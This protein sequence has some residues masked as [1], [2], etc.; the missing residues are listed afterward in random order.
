M[1][2]KPDGYLNARAA[3]PLGLPCCVCKF[4]R[5]PKNTGL[6]LWRCV[7][8]GDSKVVAKYG[9]CPRHTYKNSED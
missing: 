7:L 3:G 9:T 2:T 6:Q 4:G 1:R 5:S 8:R